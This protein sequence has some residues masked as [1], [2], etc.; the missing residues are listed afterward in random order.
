MASN[1][2]SAA[3]RAASAATIRARSASVAAFVIRKPSGEKAFPGAIAADRFDAALATGPARPIW[4]A[5]AAPSAWTASVSRRGPGTTNA[6]SVPGGAVCRPGAS[7]A[8]TTHERR[9]F[10]HRLDR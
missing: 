6:R 7:A 9:R 10:K 1:P 3:S 8:S 5:T 2:D 4:A